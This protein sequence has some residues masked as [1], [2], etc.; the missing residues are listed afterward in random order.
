M[1]ISNT[2]TDS[3]VISISSLASP[4]LS[5]DTFNTSVTD[6]DNLFDNESGTRILFYKIEESSWSVLKPFLI[7]LKR[8]P[9]R[10]KGIRGKDIRDSDITLDQH[11]VKQLR[12]L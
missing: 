11:V 5:L 10:V 12:C 3:N 4:Q 1:P 9:N 8:M 7:Y 6:P 2:G